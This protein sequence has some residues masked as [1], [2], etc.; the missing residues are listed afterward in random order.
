MTQVSPH[1]YQ[2]HIPDKHYMHPGGTNIYFIGDPKKT[3]LMLDT[4]E[5]DRSWTKQIL[6]YWKDELGSPKISSILISHGHGDHTGGVDRIQEATGAIVRCHPK[7]VKELRRVLS[8][9]DKVVPLKS[10]EML[11]LGEDVALKAIF[12]PGHAVDHVC[13]NLSKERVL[14]TGDTILG[15]SSSSVMDL[16]DYMKTLEKLAKLR[17]NTICPAHGPVVPSPKGPV[18]AK[19]Y[20]DHRNMREKQVLET[21]ENGIDSIESI[22]K[23]VYPKNLK[24]DL[25]KPAER[26]IKTHL[27]KLIKDKVVEEVEITY[28]LVN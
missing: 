21:L 27:D 4:G 1:V 22:R 24:K 25:R 5:H 8:D 11:R 7:L 3:M 10:G 20:I 18:L 23:T 17:V 9:D 12:T 19:S 26:N 2:C 16:K 13:Y 28:K 15:A 6:D 14:F